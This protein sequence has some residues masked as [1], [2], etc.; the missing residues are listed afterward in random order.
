MVVINVQL[1]SIFQSLLPSPRVHS[2]VAI[3]QRKAPM[4]SQPS[5]YAAPCFTLRVAGARCIT[6]PVDG[7]R[8][9]HQELRN[10]FCDSTSVIYLMEIHGD[11]TIKDGAHGLHGPWMTDYRTTDMVRLRGENHHCLTK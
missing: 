10:I 2:T 1:T 5:S 8:F 4:P 11:Q 6:V 7:N 3:E 9:K